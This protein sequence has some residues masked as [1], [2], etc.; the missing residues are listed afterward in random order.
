VIKCNLWS[1]SR[2]SS[3]IKIRQGCILVIDGLCILNMLVGSQV[4]VL[5]FFNEI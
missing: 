1:P 3:S 4:F 5:H 2:I